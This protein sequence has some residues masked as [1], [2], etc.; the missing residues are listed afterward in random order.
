MNKSLIYSLALIP[1]CAL[2]ACDGKRAT[3]PD[4]PVFGQFRVLPDSNIGAAPAQLL[5]V[6]GNYRPAEAMDDAQITREITA[7][8]S[9]DPMLSNSP[10]KVTTSGGV[11]SLIGAVES[12]TA[13]HRASAIAIQVKGVI[14]VDNRLSLMVSL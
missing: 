9:G 5:Q 12:L 6:A 1:V 7:A 11:V 4:R 14:S 8:F 10:I 3:T 2:T 13:V